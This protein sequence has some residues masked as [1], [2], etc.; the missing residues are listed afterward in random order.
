MLYLFILVSKT[1]LEI[2]PDWVKHVYNTRK[3]TLG[4]NF[5]VAVF[6]IKAHAFT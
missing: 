4:A 1:C 3:S 2:S 6:L 5:F